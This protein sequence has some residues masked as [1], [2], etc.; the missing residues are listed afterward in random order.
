M[1]SENSTATGY[2]TCPS[3][4]EG[5]FITAETERGVKTWT[6]AACGSCGRAFAGDEDWDDEEDED[7]ESAPGGSRAA[8]ERT[9]GA[10]EGTGAGRRQAGEGT[11][12]GRGAAGAGTEAPGAGSEGRAETG[13]ADLPPVKNR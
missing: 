3:C 10:G 7:W 12:A 8:G 9:G 13:A 6:P 2:V 11:S 5:T 1:H 4:E